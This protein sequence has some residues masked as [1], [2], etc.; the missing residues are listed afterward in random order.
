MGLYHLGMTNTETTQ[1]LTTG[2]LAMLA[3]YGEAVLIESIDA[4][5]SVLVRK[6]RG[7]Q[8]LVRVEATELTS[9]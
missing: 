5:G 1:Q 2:T 7:K 8:R 4:D 6:P 3:G 9:L